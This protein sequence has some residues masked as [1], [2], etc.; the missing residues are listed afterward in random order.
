MKIHRELLSSKM[1]RVMIDSEDEKIVRHFNNPRNYADVIIEQIN[2]ERM[3]DEMFEGEEDLVVLD[4]GGNVGLFTM[5]VQDC[6]K[7]VYTVEPTPDHFYILGE[8]TKQFPNVHPINVALFN[9]DTEIDFYISEE[10][11]TMNSAVNQYGKKTPV[12]ARRVGSIM[13]ELGL[14]HVDFVKCDIEG[15]EM[16]ALNDDTIGEIKDKIDNW[17]LE[18]HAT[19]TGSIESNREIIKSVF[20]R[21]GYEVQYFKHDGLFAFNPAQ[22]DKE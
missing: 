17:F 22:Y 2:T 4:I 15:S 18:I 19:S 5:Y 1:T 7:A 6:A 8:L 3:Y 21:A 16:A 13:K 14:D 20:E 12:Q 11:S 9:E 10:N